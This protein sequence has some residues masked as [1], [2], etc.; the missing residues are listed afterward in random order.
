MK[1]INTLSVNGNAYELEDA[2][3]VAFDR[4]QAL[5]DNEKQQALKNLGLGGQY[6]LIEDITLEEI[7]KHSAMSKTRFCSLFAEITGTSFKNYL[8]MFRIKKAGELILTGE[9]LSAVSAL[10]GYNDFSTFYRNFKKY[11][12]VS[13]AEYQEIALRKRLEDGHPFLL[14]KS[15]EE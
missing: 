10:C 4:A 14:S 5:T 9:K 3:A 11:M 6:E 2:G 15:P 12:S 1:K 13:P 8:N 7:T